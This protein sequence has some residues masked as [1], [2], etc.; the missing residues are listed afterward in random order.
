MKLFNRNS[1]GFD[2]EI[3]RLE[4]HL[5]LV[6]HPVAPRPAFI[7]NLKARLF[8][9]DL[10]PETSRIPV[11]V[12]NILLVAGGVVG[13]VLMVIASVRGILSLIN[14]LGSYINNRNSQN[15]QITPA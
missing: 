15:Q 5:E 3:K 2:M 11:K 12:S 1:T 4:R 7:K 10:P 9:G 6:L 13:S 8:A 14:I